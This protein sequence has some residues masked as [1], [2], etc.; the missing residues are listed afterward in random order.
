MGPWGQ[1]H[2]AIVAKC[3]H[4]EFGTNNFTR[5]IYQGLI[6]PT[7]LRPAF[8]HAD[9]KVQKYNQVTS[10]FLHFWD[11]HIKSLL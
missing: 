5:D 2:Q 11:L 10:V 9:T 3:W 1:F 6:S 4:S 8:T 7:C